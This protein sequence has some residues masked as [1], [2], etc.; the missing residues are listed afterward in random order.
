LVG[1]GASARPFEP[2]EWSACLRVLE[3]LCQ[4]PESAPDRQRL[5]RLAARIYKKARKERRKA[6]ALG[7]R[8]H[9]RLLVEQT[10]LVRAVPLVGQ[11]P[12]PPDENQ[13]Q[14]G[15]LRSRSRRCYICHRR[16]REIHFHYHWL[17]PDCARF[18]FEKRGQ[19][20]DLR[21]RRA[22][23][24]GGRIKI[25][26][27]TA[28]ALLRNGAEVLVTTRFPRDAALR[29]AQQADFLAWKERLRIDPLDLRLLPEVV[30]F[31]DRLLAELPCLDILINNAA[32][33]VRRPPDYY[34]KPAALEL[35]P[36]ND[37]PANLQPLIGV[38]SPDALRS[39][40][41]QP[42]LETG[43]RP[44]EEPRA[45]LPVW[46]DRHG[47]PLD[48]R[49]STSWT[50]RLGDVGVVEL[51][52][53]LVVNATAPCLLTGRLKPLFLRSRF[54]DRY[55]VNVSGLDGQFGRSV[56]TDR[57]PHVN[58][59]KAALNMMTRTSA[60]DYARDRIFMNSVDTGWITLEGAY[61]TRVR[62]RAR[63]FVP[64]LDEVDGAARICDPIMRG[65][66][67][68]RDWGQFFKDYRPAAW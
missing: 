4:E 53:V 49:E 67:G 8:Q 42:A 54:P 31:T 34:A 64:P 29:F 22:I 16:Y 48:R 3:S 68:E 46:Y 18:N 25:G 14:S 10:G 7:R 30:A 12:V 60:A 15:Q 61:S 11:A 38:S 57:H 41:I 33:S 20:T 27:Q 44:I 35:L 23:V 24:T 51:V 47:E 66:R 40:S 45:L 63:G 65:V 56:K 39:G 37:L 6:S 13:P 58:M 5:E 28:L 1:S 50:A 2:E 32:Q 26:H 36:L 19:Q 17:C 62:L 43:G 55:V 9:D 52:E 21:G 59:S